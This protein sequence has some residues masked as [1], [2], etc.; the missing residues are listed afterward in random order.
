[1]VMAKLIFFQKCVLKYPRT[2]VLER[3]T[4]LCNRQCF[5]SC[6]I[7]HGRSQE[8]DLE[9]GESEHERHKA[10]LISLSAC[11]IYTAPSF[12]SLVTNITK[13]TRD[14]HWVAVFELY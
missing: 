7:V 11:E 12:K 10:V 6:G 5:I 3:R 8:T 9:R 2:N 14:L 1:M 13:Y 4:C